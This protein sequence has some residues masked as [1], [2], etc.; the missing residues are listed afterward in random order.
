MNLEFLSECCHSIGANQVS[1]W[2][3][4]FDTHSQ[5]FMKSGD[6]TAEEIETGGGFTSL[7]ELPK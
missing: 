6:E 5:G 1:E 2:Y 7:G 4:H 3:E